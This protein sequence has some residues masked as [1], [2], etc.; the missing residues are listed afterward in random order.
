MKAIDMQ[1]ILMSKERGPM[2]RTQDIMNQLFESFNSPD[3]VM[4]SEEEMI[5][6][7]RQFDVKVV[8]FTGTLRTLGWTD[9]GEIKARND[10]IGE[11]KR[12]YPDVIL[13]A[14]IALDPDWG[15][16]GLLELERCIKDLKLFGIAACGAMTGVP[17]SDKVWHPFYE[18]CIEAKVPVKIWVGHIAI[19]GRGIP[20]WTERPIPYV[21]EVACKFPDLTIICAHHPWPF[22]HEMVSVLVHHPNVYNEQHGWSPKYFSPRFKS[23]INSRIQDKV[24]FGTDYPLFSYERM[25]KDWEAEGYKPEVL[26]KVFYKN[27]QR[28]LGN[29]GIEV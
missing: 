20:L 4:R 14:W 19:K 5:R 13:G 1:G 22:H 2:F 27:A 8:F 6:E 3:Q 12:K 10:Y 25:F 21:D 15:R 9:F 26:E 18:L 29:L 11:L 28:V 17:S 16:K 24:M 7:L 23:E